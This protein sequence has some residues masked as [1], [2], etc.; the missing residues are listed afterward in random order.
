MAIFSPHAALE[1]SDDPDFTRTFHEGEVAPRS[2]IYRCR[3]CGAETVAKKTVCYSARLH[4]LG[5]K[6]C[7]A[8]RL[9][10]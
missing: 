9:E 10:E 2:G 3:K 7:N 8:Q 6:M 1:R 5:D 4:A